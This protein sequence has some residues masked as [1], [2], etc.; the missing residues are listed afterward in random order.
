MRIYLDVE[1]PLLRLPHVGASAS[2]FVTH[3]NL[4]DLDPYLRITPELFRRAAPEMEIL[5]PLVGPG[6]WRR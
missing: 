3:S 5:I 4:V 1:T 2:P 6:E